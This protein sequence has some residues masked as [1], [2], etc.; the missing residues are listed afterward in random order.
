MNNYNYIITTWID[1]KQEIEHTLLRLA[2]DT[3]TNI[4]YF[5]IKC[6]AEQFGPNY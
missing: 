1:K 3:P 6:R 5:E 2:L 4:C